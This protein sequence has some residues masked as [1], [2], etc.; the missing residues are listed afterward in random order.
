[1]ARLSQADNHHG[2]GTNRHD[3]AI[4]ASAV[5]MIRFGS[6]R[7]LCSPGTMRAVGH[8]VTPG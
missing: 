4:I 8:G 5:M 2:H 3:V 6:I 1:M 7:L